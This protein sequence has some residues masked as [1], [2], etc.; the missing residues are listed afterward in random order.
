[1][2]GK[3][4]DDYDH[5]SYGDGED[6]KEFFEK[7]GQSPSTGRAKKIRGYAIDAE[8]K[9]EDD[10]AEAK[11]TLCQYAHVGTSYIPTT[12]TIKKLPSGCY[13][14]VILNHQLALDRIKIV[15]DKLI[16]FPDTKSDGVIA[17][18]EEFWKLKKKFQEFGFSH[19]RGFL[20]WGPPGSGKTC[21]LSIIINKMV[22]AGGLVIVADSPN[23]L[24][25]I[26][27]QLRTIEP[28][29]PVVIVWEDI[30]AV[31]DQYGESEVLSILDGESQI[32]N[33]VFIATTNY[34]EKLDKR[35]TN[36]P[37]RFDKIVKIGMPSDEARALYLKDKIG[38]VVA[39]DGTD[40]VKETKGMSFAHMRE[41]IV[42]I[43]CQGNDPKKVIDRLK[44][45]NIT[46]RSG[47]SG[48][49]GLAQEG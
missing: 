25:G 3:S 28:K 38:D 4:N 45:M 42:G 7:A 18:V 8:E 1:M 17:E 47:D 20:L 10:E 12:E 14:V 23:H 43:Y 41:L 32:D 6:E 29:R 36:R 9:K 24:A 44:K 33:V 39:K 27:P 34:P 15:T 5:G 13:R 21:T 49:M 16:Q 40:L 26:L 2:S 30:D 19:K 35:I 37:S 22:K 11:G 48:V 46:P 31:I